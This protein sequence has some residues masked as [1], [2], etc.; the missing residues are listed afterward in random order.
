MITPTLLSIFERELNRLKTEILSYQS[1]ENIWRIQGHILNSGGNLTLHLIGNLNTYIGLALGKTGYERNREEEFSLK[2]VPRHRLIS[3][4]EDT[5]AMI[6]QTLLR[7]T[8]EDYRWE[9]PMQ[10]FEK[11]TSTEYMLIH[12]ASHL[13]YHL[14]QINYHRRLVEA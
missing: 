5:A 4:I 7:L 1:E 13:S 10:V 6:H 9:Y 8:E 2:N 11:K 3:E 12:L 14:G